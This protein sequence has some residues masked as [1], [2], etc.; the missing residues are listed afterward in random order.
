VTTTSPRRWQLVQSLKNKEYRHAFVADEIGIGIPFQIRALREARG[1][2]QEELGRQ[3]AMAQERISQ[4]ESTDY[5]RY[6]LGTLKRLALAFDVGL[7]VHFVPFSR[8]VD[9]AAHLSAEMLS[10]P[11]YDEDEGLA[12]KTEKK[13]DMTLGAPSRTANVATF[14]SAGYASGLPGM[15]ST[16]VMEA[17]PIPAIEMPAARQ[18]G[19]PTVPSTAFSLTG[20]IQSLRRAVS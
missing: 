11:S 2:T 18:L 3:A 8:M 5:G 16:G 1:W 4:L 9:W 12:D 7:E 19:M 20:H 10:P 13:A 6:T 14:P 17:R 15:V